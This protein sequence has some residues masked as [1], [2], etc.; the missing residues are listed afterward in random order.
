MNSASL[1]GLMCAIRGPIMLITIGT[2]F[3]IDNAGGFPFYRTW[4]VLIIVFGFL[5]LLERAVMR[6]AA[7]VPP[8]G[9]GM[10]T[11]TGVPGTPGGSAL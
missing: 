8:A 3:A 11:G 7:Y 6:P 9:G 2:L 10:A 4:P 1:G 5:K